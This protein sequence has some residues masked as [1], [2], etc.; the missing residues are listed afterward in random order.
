MTLHQFDNKYWYTDELKK[1]AKEIG[2]PSASSLRKDQLEK[3]IRG[4][5]QS[6]KLE[7]PAKNRSARAGPWDSE[8]G[9]SSKLRVVNYRNDKPTWDFVEREARKITGAKSKS[10]AR[11]RLNRWREQQIE[12]GLRITYGD[13][14]GEYARLNQAKEPFAPIAHA[15][16]INFLSDFFASEKNATHE[17]ARRAWAEVKKLDAPKTY[18][19]WVRHKS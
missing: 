7:T 18:R 19:S 2:I 3:A 13:L 1:L 4:F 6:G 10:G 14:A 9:L 12:N 16:Y 15:R 8:R 5:L 11:Y 17:K